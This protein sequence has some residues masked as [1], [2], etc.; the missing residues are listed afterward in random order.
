M[1]PMAFLLLATCPWLRGSLGA[2]DNGACESDE[3]DLLQRSSRVALHSA[4][5]PFRG[6]GT[7]AHAAQRSGAEHGSLSNASMG[8]EL[9][10]HGNYYGFRFEGGFGRGDWCLNSH[11]EGGAF[12]KMAAETALK[13]DALNRFGLEIGPLDW[14]GFIRPARRYAVRYDDDRELALEELGPCASEAECPHWANPSP[15]EGELQN[16]FQYPPYQDVPWDQAPRSQFSGTWCNYKQVDKPSL[17]QCAGLDV[18]S[19]FSVFG[20]GGL[21]SVHTTDSNLT[22]PHLVDIDAMNK[23]LPL[24]GASL[25]PHGDTLPTATINVTLVSYGFDP[26]FEDK[27]VYAEDGPGIFLEHHLFT[28]YFMNYHENVYPAQNGTESAIIALARQADPSEDCQA[29]PCEYW[30][31]AF[32]VP[33]GYTIHCPPGCIH[34]D[35]TNKGKEVTSL[36]DWKDADVV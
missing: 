25:V 17:P 19:K 29:N 21:L 14:Y 12:T 2:E 33:S 1:R 8:T 22:V 15:T 7:S 20:S 16:G 4:Q 23:T 5:G 13:Y 36:A 9:V 3:A 28:H 30:I 27:W 35:W 34:E 10:C 31:T 32:S 6:P 24:Y 18:A 11:S 26:S